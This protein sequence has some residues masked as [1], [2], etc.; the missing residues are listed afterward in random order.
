MA[1]NSRSRTSSPQL[2]SNSSNSPTVYDLSPV[3]IPLVNTPPTPMS[4]SPILQPPVAHQNRVTSQPFKP[5][6]FS[7]TS[8]NMS[9]FNLITSYS[10]STAPIFPPL[11]FENML[12]NE[13]MMEFL[14]MMTPSLGDF[15]TSR[16]NYDYMYPTSSSVRS[17]VSE[18][19]LTYDKETGSTSPSS[20][21]S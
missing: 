20:G 13:A 16:A 21:R 9:P 19:M 12:P 4:H 17:S 18:G 2:V 7:S 6:K 14:S 3:H 15:Q 11:G 10:S 5:S 1:D 8:S